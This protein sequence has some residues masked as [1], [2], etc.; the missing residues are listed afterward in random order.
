MAT[1]NFGIGA[2]KSLS[3]GSYNQYAQV[4]VTE[5]KIV[6]PGLIITAKHMNAAA[7]WPLVL[8]NR[9]VRV[10]A[11]GNGRIHAQVQGAYVNRPYGAS[12][13][14]TDWDLAGYLNGE[15]K[16]ATNPFAPAPKPEVKTVNDLFVLFGYTVPTSAPTPAPKPTFSAPTHKPAFVPT[17]A[18]KTTVTPS[19]FGKVTSLAGTG[20]EYTL[21]FCQDH[22]IITPAGILDGTMIRKA[23]ALAGGNLDRKFV[24]VR[25][26]GG[27]SIHAQLPDDDANRPYGT[28]FDFVDAALAAYLR[29]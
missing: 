26:N 16:P 11:V 18:P 19:N 22:K 29:G 9:I 6:A 2:V 4:L 3:N 20:K 12:F 5:G 14:F 15:A 7:P 1:K 17:A 13:D 24:Q 27:N 23:C 21:V 8:D 25:L 28:S 10:R